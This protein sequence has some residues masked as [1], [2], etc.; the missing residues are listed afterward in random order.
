MTHLYAA[1][2]KTRRDA[3]SSHRQGIH[4]LQQANGDIQAVREDARVVLES[5]C[6]PP[7]RQVFQA[8]FLRCKP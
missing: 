5:S 8:L 6:A 4:Y 2:L 3:C 1:A 7:G